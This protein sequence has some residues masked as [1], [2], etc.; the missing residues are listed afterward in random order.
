MIF[1]VIFD[2]PIWSQS[3]FRNRTLKLNVPRATKRVTVE[4]YNARDPL[5]P[6]AYPSLERKQCGWR[7]TKRLY[8]SSRCPLELLISGYCYAL[9]ADNRAEQTCKL[10][11]LLLA[12]KN[13]Y[14]GFLLQRRIPIYH[15]RHK[16]SGRRYSTGENAWII[17]LPPPSSS[18]PGEFAIPPGIIVP[19]K[20]DTANY[21]PYVARCR[22][23][24]REKPAYITHAASPRVLAA[25]DEK[26][27]WKKKKDHQN[28]TFRKS[29]PESC[30][31]VDVI[32]LLR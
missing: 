1:N 13:M 14:R 5:S 2:V 28:C 24:A 18:L 8:P 22:L 10:Q 23:A 26:M 17:W 29:V 19:W 15:A 20:L 12:Y 16:N 21:S 9:V 3:K 6:R 31:T 32:P 30:L 4:R 25:S 11:V 7:V 27:F